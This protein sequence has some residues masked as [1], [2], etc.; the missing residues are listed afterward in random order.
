[1]SGHVLRVDM[2]T[3]RKLEWRAYFGSSHMRTVN[4]CAACENNDFAGV[5]ES[6]DTGETWILG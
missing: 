1:M 2:S 4:E 6:R 3:L 5:P